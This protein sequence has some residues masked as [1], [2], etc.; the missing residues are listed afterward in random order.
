MRTAAHLHWINNQEI[1]SAYKCSRIWRPYFCKC[2]K[3]RERAYGFKPNLSVD[4]IYQNVSSNDVIPPPLLRPSFYFKSGENS[5]FSLIL[6]NLRC[7]RIFV[8]LFELVSP[9]FPGSWKHKEGGNTKLSKNT[10]STS[11]VKAIPGDWLHFSRRSFAINRE[12]SRAPPFEAVH[13][14]KKKFVTYF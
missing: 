2:R 3:K 4:R 14:S 7:D 6:P 12:R 9:I 11:R 13:F 1:I 8:F 5:N 10:S